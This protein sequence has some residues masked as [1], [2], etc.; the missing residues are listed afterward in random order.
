MSP[1]FLCFL[2][3]TLAAIDK[4]PRPEPQPLVGDTLPAGAVA[5]LGPDA[6]RYAGWVEVAR[7]ARGATGVTLR[8]QAEPRSTYA[9]RSFGADGYSYRV[10]ARID[11]QR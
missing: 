1:S 5:R 7:A 11:L 9:V 4:R 6:F 3:L 10:V 8:R 2:A